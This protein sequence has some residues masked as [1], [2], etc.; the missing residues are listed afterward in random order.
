M[1]NKVLIVGDLHLP[2]CL[3]AYLAFCKKT[4]KK[5]KCDR[6]VFI[7][8]VVDH[9]VISFHDKHPKAPGVMEE[10]EHCLKEVAKWHKAFPN[11]EVV[12]GNHD[13]RHQ[14]ICAKSQIPD[15]Y[16]KDFTTLFNTPGWIWKKDVSIDGVWYVHG[17]GVAS[18]SSVLPAATLA[19][20]VGGSVVLGHFHTKAGLATF[21]IQ[22]KRNV[23]GL[24]VGCGVDDTHQAMAYSTSVYR[25][26][27]SCGV[28]LNGKK[29]Y[30]EVMD[31]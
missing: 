31:E 23:F 11:A 9:H 10:Y 4:Y 18:S 1:S 30:L 19:Q 12:I 20:K 15:I 26:V 28:V 22:N 29:A 8:D 21:N 16:L 25:P 6:V 17:H 13:E 14:R 2:A 24:N 3:E 5:Y 7:G 27:L